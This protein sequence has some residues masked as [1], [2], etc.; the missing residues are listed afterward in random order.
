MKLHS[1]FLPALAGTAAAKTAP[2]QAEA[3]IL[4]QQHPQTTTSNPPSIPNELAEAILLQRLSSPEQPSTLGQLPESLGQDEAVSFI[5]QFGKPSPPLFQDA[6]AGEPNQLVIAFS[7][8]TDDRYDELKKTIS[9]VPL[10]FTA[11]EL[12]QVSIRETTSCS[13]E[14][15]IE[16]QSSKCWKGKTQYLHYDATKDKSIVAQ[17]E[18][19]L[20][21][22][23]AQASEGKLETTILFLPPSGAGSEQELRRRDKTEQVL[24]SGAADF[25]KDV[26]ASSKPAKSFYAAADRP[27]V[28]P[29]CFASHNACMTATNEC[30]GHGACIDK[31]TDSEESCF[32]CRCKAAKEYDEVYKR[33]L[34]YQWGGGACQKRDVSTPFWLFAGVTIALV[35]TVAFSIGL[36]FSVGEEKLPGVIGAGVSR[37]K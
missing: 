3:Y 37:S 34:L 16:P 21:F 26:K 1:F 11:P 7:G 14:A 2:R 35:S 17:L 9:G 15:S 25:F 30:S 24:T 31:W 33:D 10:A 19:N 12:S 18:T 20:V 23:K 13:F 36:L 4:R 8:I 5:N 28:I 6:D 27:T 32:F 22:L 29:S